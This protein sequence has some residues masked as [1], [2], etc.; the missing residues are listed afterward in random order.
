MCGILLSLSRQADWDTEWW[1]RLCR[2]IDRRGPDFSQIFTTQT[3]A[4]PLKTCS[5]V[6]AIRPPLT[7]QP[8][9]STNGSILQFNGELYND[10]IEG[11][12]TAYIMSVMERL[13]VPEAIRIMK[14]EYAF[15]YY[16]AMEN[17]VWFARDPVGRRSLLCLLTPQGLALSSVGMPGTQFEEVNAHC[18]FCVDILKWEI[19]T[20]DHLSFGKVFDELCGLEGYGQGISWDQQLE[21]V[22]QEAVQKRVDTVFEALEPVE[23]EILVAQYQP[24]LYPKP[25]R[26]AIL[27][28]GGLDCTLLAMLAH[29]VAPPEET[30]DLLNVAFEN[31]RTGEGYQTPDRLLG[32]RSHA[33]LLELCKPQKDRFRFVE[34]NVPY[35]EVQQHKALVEELMWP[36]D[37]VMDFSIAL[38]F[39]FASRGIG[40]VLGQPYTSSVPVLLSGLGA[41]ELFGGYTRHVA[42]IEKDYGYQE[43]AKELQL[44]F[45]R[46]YERNLGR[47]DRVC[48]IWGKELRY[49][50]LDEQVIKWAL[51]C[52]IEQKVARNADGVVESKVILRQMA[53][54]NGLKLV[55]EEKKRA[56]QFGARSAKMDPGSGKL[57]GTDRI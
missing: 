33:E 46:L 49:A 37:S 54:R 34:I 41:D 5:S 21:E 24:I 39:Y 12:D 7:E 19:Q 22:L 56:I 52:P 27:F 31:L 17:K 51:D 2:H 44:D 3:I 10:N 40:E 18:I 47:D 14:G 9:V 4:G 28:S 25:V 45:D 6:L 11:N 20:F 16:D 35:E 8:M 30:I 36:K 42:K 32:R 55:S 13:G 15:T 50:F 57:K 1:E 43:L 48:A 23:P 53:R 38:A 26:I 29:R